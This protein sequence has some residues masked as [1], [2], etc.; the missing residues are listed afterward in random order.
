MTSS[1]AYDG[2]YR[3]MRWFRCDLHLHTPE[4]SRHWLDDDLKLGKWLL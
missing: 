2:A 1:S 3:G 4:D